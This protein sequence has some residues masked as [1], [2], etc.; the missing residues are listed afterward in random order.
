MRQGGMDHAF[1][2]IRVNTDAQV[3]A[4]LLGS[5]YGEHGDSALLV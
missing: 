5:G 1:K 3:R 2:Q 4:M